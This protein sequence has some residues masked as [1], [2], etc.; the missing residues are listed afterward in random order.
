[1]QGRTVKQGQT[2][3]GI[4]DK[5]NAVRPAATVDPTGCGDAYRAGL[6]YGLMNEFDWATTGSIAALMGSLKIAHHGT[7][8]HQ[9]TSQEF[10]DRF[11]REFGYR[12]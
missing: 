2:L 5:G 8:N 7:Q 11:T 6:L 4:E 1:M 12:F 9:Y 10:H 3:A